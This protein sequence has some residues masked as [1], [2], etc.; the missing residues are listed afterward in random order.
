MALSDEEVREQFGYSGKSLH[1]R[2]G[3]DA[4]LQDSRIELQ[5][6]RKENAELRERIEADRQTSEDEMNYYN[7][8]ERDQASRSGLSFTHGAFGNHNPPKDKP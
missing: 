3:F 1:W 7:R 4:A 8:D 5:Q 2:R 6:L